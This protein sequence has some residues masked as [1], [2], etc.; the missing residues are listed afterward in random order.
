M[1][2]TPIVHDFVDETEALTSLKGFFEAWRRLAKTTALN[3]IEC[4]ALETRKL[5]NVTP[6]VL[7]RMIDRERPCILLDEVDNQDL[8]TSSTLRAVLNS[9]H[10]AGGSISRL[11]KGEAKT[12]STFA[13]IARCDFATPDNRRA[14]SITM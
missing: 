8:P 6:A 13:P 7:F 1:S 2:I 10:Y 3:L 12:F 14:S 5:D 4:L 11:I 9:G